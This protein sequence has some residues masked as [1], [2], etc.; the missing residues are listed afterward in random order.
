MRLLLIRHGRSAHV[1]PGGLLDR[2]GVERWRDAYDEAGIADDSHPPPALVEDVARAHR[3]VA[4]DLPRAIASA[5]RLAPARDVVISP[6]FREVPLLIPRALPFRVPRGVWEAAIHLRWGVD[7]IR[8][9]GA[10]LDAIDRARSAA[11]WCQEECGRC[12]SG[13]GTIA[14]VTHG[15]FRR[16]LL[17]VLMARGWREEASRRSYAHW[18]VW[19]LRL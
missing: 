8:R 15:V 1:H 7:L 2:A 12:D 4:S 16:M 19:R 6:L 14:V 13:A 9:R 18:S 10:P 17:E 5:S 11:E 3:L